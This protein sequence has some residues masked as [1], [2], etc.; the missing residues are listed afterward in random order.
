MRVVSTH[1]GRDET[2]M[3]VDRQEFVSQLSSGVLALV[4]QGRPTVNLAPPP[5]CYSC[6]FTRNIN[7]QLSILWYFII[8]F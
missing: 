6:E 7:I 8:Y 5:V 1:L 4:W 2:K 3:I